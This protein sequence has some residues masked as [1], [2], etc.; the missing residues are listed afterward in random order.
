MLGIAQRG[1]GAGAAGL[2]LEQIAVEDKNENDADQATG[3]K[4]VKI[5]MLFILHHQDTFFKQAV[6]FIEDG[7]IDTANI[8]PG[9]VDG[10]NI[11]R[12]AARFRVLRSFN[13]T[14]PVLKSVCE[15]IDVVAN[16]IDPAGLRNIIGTEFGK[17]RHLFGELRFFIVI[18]AQKIR[19]S[20]EQIAPLGC[21]H[22]FDNR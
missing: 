9:I 1:L 20:G 7:I 2:H 4:R 12:G 21:Q 10:S 8:D 17:G 5:L 6:F 22:A 15:H 18:F 13:F 3:Q 16:F 19:A 11:F 14:R